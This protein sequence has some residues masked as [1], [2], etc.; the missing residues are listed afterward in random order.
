[1]DTIA[2]RL[3]EALRLRELSQT[4]LAEL[5]GVSQGTIGNIS[6]GARDGLQSLPVIA[7]ALRVR[8]EWLRF[9]EEPMEP[10]TLDWPF[11]GVPPERFALLT[12]RQ[13]GEVERAMIDAIAS[14]EAR[15]GNRNG[16]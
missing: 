6:S 4:K 9:G 5:A 13:K 8:Y 15:M 11:E 14:I 7:S 12:E 1:M 16:T 3:K 2:S 10:P